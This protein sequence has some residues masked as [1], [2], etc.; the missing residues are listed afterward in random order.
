MA[1]QVI[2]SVTS[3]SNG[4]SYD[5]KWDSYNKDTYVSYA[6]WSFVGT[7]SDSG[8]ALSISTGWLASNS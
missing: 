4:K 5:V 6:G 2:G 1:A 3:P 8:E 7:A